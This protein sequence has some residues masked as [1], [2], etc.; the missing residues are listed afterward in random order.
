[1]PRGSVAAPVALSGI[2]LSGE[3]GPRLWAPGKS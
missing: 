2:A 1:M 3:P